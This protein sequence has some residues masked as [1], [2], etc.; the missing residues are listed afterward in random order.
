MWHVV[1][2]PRP[3]REASP[4]TGAGLC[5]GEGQ[6]AHGTCVRVRPVRGQGSLALALGS[7]PVVEVGTGEEQG[8]GYL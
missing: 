2:V 5:W 7:A 1:R 6:V 4:R 3:P 8:G